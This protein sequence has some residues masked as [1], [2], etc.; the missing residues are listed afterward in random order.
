MIFNTKLDTVNENEN[1]NETEKEKQCLIKINKLLPFELVDL[2]KDF[3]PLTSILFLNKSI[4]TQYHTFVRKMISKLKIENYIRDML[5]RDN[6]F[7]FHF[8]FKENCDK[9]AKIKNYIYKN[10]I[11]KNYI[12]FVKDFC[13]ENESHK[14]RKIL[15]DFIKEDGLC[16]NQHKNNIHKNKRWK[17]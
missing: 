3:L 1:E 6:S 5:R 2:I 13:I 11:Y 9:W 14:C 12:N 8:I 10:I 15:N 17:I 16:Q 4:Y 7:V